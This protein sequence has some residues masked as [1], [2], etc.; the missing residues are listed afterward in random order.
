MEDNS[1]FKQRKLIQKKELQPGVFEYTF[2]Y[3]KGFIPRQVVSLRWDVNMPGRLYSIM[4]GLSE[5][6]I[7]ILFNINPNG[8]LTPRMAKMQPGDKLYISDPMGK[9]LGV[10]EP[11]YW[12]ATGTGIAPFIS[13]MRSGMTDDKVLIQGARTLNQ[14]YY[15]EE[16]EK[17]FG[18]FYIR[19]CSQESKEGV[20]QGRLTFYLEMEEQLPKDYKYYLCGSSEMVVEVRDILIR[21]GIPFDNILAEIYF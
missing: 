15:S 20:F 21:K 7:K 3:D 18:Q 14:F 1:D 16:L 12:I 11:A 9:F 10:N 5:E 19:C 4:S 8:N 13:M 6:G 17:K 2:E